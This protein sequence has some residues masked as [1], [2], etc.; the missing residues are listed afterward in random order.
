[1]KKKKW[2]GLKDDPMKQCCCNCTMR[3]PLHYHC[4]IDPPP[5]KRK[6]DCG[7]GKIKGYVCIVF[8][9]KRIHM[10]FKHS[11]GCEMYTAKNGSGKKCGRSSLPPWPD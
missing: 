2:C 3:V 10:T 7:C 6:D 9:P 1:M 11:V 8:S 4:M 5:K